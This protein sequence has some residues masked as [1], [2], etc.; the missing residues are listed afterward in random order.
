MTEIVYSPEALEDLYSILYSFTSLYGKTEAKDVLR[1]NISDIR[2]L[3]QNPL[4]GKSLQK[5]LDVTIDYCYLIS[6]R[7]YIFYYYEFD[8]IHIVRI[9]NEKKDYIQKILG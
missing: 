1:K 7:N 3:E 4:L 5:V 9:L 2:K 6:E 8:R